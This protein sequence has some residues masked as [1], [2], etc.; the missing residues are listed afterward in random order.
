LDHPVGGALLVSKGFAMDE[1]TICAICMSDAMDSVRIAACS[2]QFCRGCIMQW[3]SSKRSCPLCNCE[4]SKIIQTAAN[5]I[6]NE[7]YIDAPSPV[8]ESYLEKDLECLDHRYFAVEARKLLS[9]AN[10]TQGTLTHAFHNNK[11][12]SKYNESHWEAIQEIIIRLDDLVAFFC[13]EDSDL[14]DPHVMLQEFYDID[15]NIRTINKGQPV[16]AQRSQRESMR[17]SAD[18]V[19]AI[20]SDEEEDDDYD[21]HVVQGKQKVQIAKPKGRQPKQHF[22]FQTGARK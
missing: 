11:S 12:C 3:A 13:A 6:Q 5:G 16:V 2:H 9:L 20:P 19:D 17:Y 4:F 14:F 22:K 1:H 21:F 8:M 7:E 15:N 18:D 10:S